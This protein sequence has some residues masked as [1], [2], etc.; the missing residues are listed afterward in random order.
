MTYVDSFH[1][2]VFQTPD[3]HRAV[4]IHARYAHHTPYKAKVSGV[5][6]ELSGIPQALGLE[7]TGD[8]IEVDRNMILL[9]HKVSNPY[10]GTTYR[11]GV[12]EGPM[13]D[14]L[15]TERV[16]DVTFTADRCL[17]A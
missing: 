2:P 1:T 9:T 8:S 4:I 5:Y 3:G 15:N 17:A 12:F 14:E 11:I 16:M 10:T 13:I 7:P 6:L